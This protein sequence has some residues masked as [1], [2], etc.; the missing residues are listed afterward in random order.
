MTEHY[1]KRRPTWHRFAIIYCVILLLFAAGAIRTIMDGHP[2]RGMHDMPLILIFLAA[3]FTFAAMTEMSQTLSWNDRLIR[4]H[5]RWGFKYLGYK[6]LAVAVAEITEI[7]A[8]YMSSETLG[9]K[10]FSM[11]EITDGVTG[12]PI[13]TDNFF[14][15]G[16]QELVA[17]IVRL[18]PDLELTENLRAY[19]QGEFDGYWPK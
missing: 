1:L 13:R 17:D 3:L 15:D 8:G 7:S 6:T 14:R 10:P 12:I 19:V 4:M 2:F 16:M 11:I 9:E 18:R 5:P